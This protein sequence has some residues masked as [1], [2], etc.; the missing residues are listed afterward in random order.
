MHVTEEITIHIFI[1]NLLRHWK[2]RVDIMIYEIFVIY[3]LA[4]PIILL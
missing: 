4:T 2:I 1:Y 3:L